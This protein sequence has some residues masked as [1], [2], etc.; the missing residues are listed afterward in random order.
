VDKDDADV[1]PEGELSPR[2]VAKLVANILADT[3]PED[4]IEDAEFSEVPGEAA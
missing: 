2:V 1:I 4:L 3:P